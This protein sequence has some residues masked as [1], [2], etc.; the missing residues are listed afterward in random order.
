[1][2]GRPY[3]TG[4]CLNIGNV[5]KK[6]SLFVCKFYIINPIFIL[7]KVNNNKLTLLNTGPL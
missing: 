7:R 3:V 6:D 1:M 4:S 5:V 2:Y